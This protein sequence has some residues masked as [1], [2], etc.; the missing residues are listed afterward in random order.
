MICMVSIRFELSVCSMLV[1]CYWLML[2]LMVRMSSSFFNRD[3][4]RC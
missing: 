4:V 2:M 1:G 3:V